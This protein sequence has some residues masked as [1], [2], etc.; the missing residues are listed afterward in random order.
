S[1]PLLVRLVALVHHAL[2]VLHLIHRHAGAGA[3]HDLG[4]EEAVGRVL[5]GL[6]LGPARLRPLVGRG[7]GAAGEHSEQ[8]QQRRDLEHDLGSAFYRRT[9][10]SV[11]TVF[12]MSW[13]RRPIAR[14]WAA[15]SA[16]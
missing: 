10:S 3:A 1:T 11:R 16:S 7:R 8:D 12:A 15:T 9:L 4:V 13:L 6:L 2:P 14:L 5:V